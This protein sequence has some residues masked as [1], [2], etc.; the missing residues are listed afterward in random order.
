MEPYRSRTAAW[1]R[2]VR[3]KT[4]ALVESDCLHPVLAYR[5]DD[6]VLWHSVCGVRR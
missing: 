4:G 2:A 1:H 3:L 5:S 6:Y